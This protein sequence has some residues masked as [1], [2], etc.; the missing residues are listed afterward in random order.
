MPPPPYINP[1]PP[2]PRQKNSRPKFFA[3]PKNSFGLETYFDPK[4]FM[5][6]NFGRTNKNLKLKFFRTLNLL[7]PKFLNQED[8]TVFVVLVHQLLLRM[9]IKPK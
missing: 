3:C 8:S 1:A 5:D 2:H 6:Q 7:D 9:V 4:I